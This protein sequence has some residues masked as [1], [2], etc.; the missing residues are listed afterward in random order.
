MDYYDFFKTKYGSELLIDLVRLET[1]EK[2]IIGKGPHVLSYYDI[3]L[4]LEGNG[5]FRLDE[6]SFDI[7]PH[8][9][10]FSSP[11]QVRKWEI[12]KMP[13]GLILIFEEEFL[14]S[15]FND[16]EFVQRLSYFNAIYHEPVLSLHA[17]DFTYFKSILENIEKEIVGKDKKDNHI[18]R[19]LLYQSLCWLNRLYLKSNTGSEPASGRY[20]YE[21]RKMANRNFKQHHS[22]CF[23]ADKL[24]ITAGHLNDMVKDHFGTSAKYF[25][26]SRLFLEAK[27]LLLYSTLSVSEIAWE[28]NFQDDSY[29]VRAFKNKMGC[30]PHSY[31]NSLN[32]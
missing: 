15:F 1:L 23:Y 3:T 24:H 7:E 13:K 2:Y 5:S 10:F 32:P 6:F 4:I 29:F 27:R 18:L 28:L 22:V 31:K 21:F 26:Q 20:V 8:K 25:I 12:E 17:S 30:T 11:M 16:S 9:I 19:A 14:C